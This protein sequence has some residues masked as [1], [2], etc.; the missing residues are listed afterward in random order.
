MFFED[1]DSIEPE[2][3]ANAGT[4]VLLHPPFSRVGVSIVRERGRQQ[5]N[6]AGPFQENLVA[7]A[8]LAY[9]AWNGDVEAL[10][11]THCAHTPQRTH[12]STHIART[13]TERTIAGSR[14]SALHGLATQPKR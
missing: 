1:L 12:E 14:G 4:A 11:H 9:V 6:S 13:W 5:F 3:L 7:A 10:R 2:N 8:Q